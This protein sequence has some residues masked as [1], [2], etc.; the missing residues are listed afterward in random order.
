MCGGAI[1]R[2]TPEFATYGDRGR[3]WYLDEAERTTKLM[4]GSAKK[5]APRAA[6]DGLP[7]QLLRRATDVEH[8]SVALVHERTRRRVREVRNVKEKCSNEKRKGGASW[9]HRNSISAVSDSSG[10]RGGFWAAWWPR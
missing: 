3:G 9:T 10:L 5:G 2:N 7:E 4:I 1:A 6:A 8:H